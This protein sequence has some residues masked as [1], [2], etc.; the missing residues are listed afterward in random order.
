MTEPDIL[1]AA[2]RI[3]ETRARGACFWHRL[4]G[5]LRKALNML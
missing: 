2:I 3:C 5:S 4:A 1:R